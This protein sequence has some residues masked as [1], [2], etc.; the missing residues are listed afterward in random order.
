[1]RAKQ[2]AATSHSTDELLQFA[3]YLKRYPL[4]IQ[5]GLAQTHQSV[6]LPDQR[7]VNSA[8]MA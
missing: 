6:K 2:N 5:E 3:R 7:S 4:S 8:K 1:M